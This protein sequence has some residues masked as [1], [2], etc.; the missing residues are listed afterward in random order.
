M[1]WEAF[2]PKAFIQGSW[3]ENQGFNGK[4]KDAPF[5]QIGL[6]I[7]FPIWT[8]LTR[9]AHIREADA[10]QLAV[11]EQRIALKEFCECGN[12]FFTW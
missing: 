5:W 2:L 6:T 1:A 4:G 11:T 10:R 9:V 8:G 7:N 3:M 12:S